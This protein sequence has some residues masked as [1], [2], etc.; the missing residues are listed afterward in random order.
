MILSEA[1]RISTV[2]RE[3]DIEGLI[4]IHGAPHDEYDSEA[5]RIRE[6][7]F[8]HRQA[9]EDEIYAIVRDVWAEL[10]ELDEQDLLKRDSAFRRVAEKLA[11]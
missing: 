5:E 7:I 6:R 2:L 11:K 3:E 4:A 1:N 8:K 10:F 9:N